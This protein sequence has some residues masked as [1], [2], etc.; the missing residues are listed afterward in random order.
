M[1]LNIPWDLLRKLLSNSISEDDYQLLLIWRKKSKLNQFIYDEILDDKDFQ[2]LLL[3]EKPIDQTEKWNELLSK[4]KPAQN[5]L[6]IKTR[7]LYWISGAAAVALLFIGLSAGIWLKGNK[8]ASSD[9]SEFT[10]VFSPRGQRTQMVLP[11][12]SR[13]WLNSETS[14][15]YS[16]N[17]NNEVR[18]VYIEGE[19]YFKVAKNPKKP[20]IVKTSDLKIKVYGTSFNV[21]AYPSEKTIETTLIE[22]KLSV[23]P[24]GFK[25]KDNNEIYLKPKDRLT[26]TKLNSKVSLGAPAEP[27]KEESK[28][29]E[30][31]TQ[32]PK[33]ILAKN[34]DPKIEESWKDGTL[35]FK[36]ELFSDLAIKLERWYDIRIHF[37]DERIKT[38][39]FTGKFDKETINEAMEALRASSQESYCYQ[40]V[41]RDV[42]LKS[43]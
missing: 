22:G 28:P 43:K 8:K 36:D 14:I 34:V 38:Y 42:Y 11:D 39:R 5:K 16:A 9:T 24:N 31:H 41:F 12:K 32:L 30:V 4:I 19:A 2:Q 1:A 26:Y 21:K 23:I 17:F 35:L 6:I 25:L 18:E 33:V 13:V 7:K 20:F 40:I 37:N 29:A 27:K 3:T 10:Y 15:R